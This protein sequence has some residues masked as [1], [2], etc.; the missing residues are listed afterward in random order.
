MTEM[1]DKPQLAGLS[2]ARILEVR[3]AIKT[4]DG[5][6]GDQWDLALARAVLAAAGHKLALTE[7]ANDACQKHG[8]ALQRAGRAA[9]LLAGSDLHTQLVPAIEALKAAAPVSG[10]QPSVTVERHR[11][12][13][14]RG[15]QS[16]MLAY[17]ADT[18]DE[19]QWY[20]GQVRGIL[21]SITP[22]VKPGRT[23]EQKP[24]AWMHDFFD[25]SGNHMTTK[26][27]GYESSPFG[28][29]GIDHSEEF[30]VE[31]TP[32]YTAPIPQADKGQD[33]LRE[34][35]DNAKAAFQELSRQ[36]MGWKVLPETLRIAETAICDIDAALVS[37]CV[38]AAIPLR[39][40][41]DPAFAVVHVHARTAGQPG[42]DA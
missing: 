31:S 11:V 35:L 6:D 16:F 40:E 17:E 32:L 27:T 26:Y 36:G 5:W 41:D 28:T 37:A 23:G 18:D 33:K 4:G 29:P 14:K 1:N 30:T 13:I 10:E 39:A 9:G 24:V 25:E 22:N 34:A 12:W 21:P 19:L 3:D 2:D 42:E 8:E 38:P 15:V 20:A 7:A